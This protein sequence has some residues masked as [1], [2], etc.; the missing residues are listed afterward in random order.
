[1]VDLLL[2]RTLD[3]IHKL[4]DKNFALDLQTVAVA[5][6]QFPTGISTLVQGW[7]MYLLLEAHT[8]SC[9]YWTVSAFR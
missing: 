8:L 3:V 2:S 6:A 5:W 9:R 4:K 7:V 1:M